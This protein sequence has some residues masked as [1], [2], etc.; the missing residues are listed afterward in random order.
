MLTC[1]HRWW[2]RNIEYFCAIW[3]LSYNGDDGDDD[4]DDD[5]DDAIVY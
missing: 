3:S 1:K 4:D 5:D 2:R